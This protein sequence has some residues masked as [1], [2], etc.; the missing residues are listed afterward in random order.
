[1]GDAQGVTRTNISISRELKARM[2]AV[3]ERVNWSAVAA[4]AFE[5]KLLELESR[6]EVRGMDDVI[7]RLKAA[8]ELEEN[9]AVQDGVTAGRGWA[10]RQATPKELRR[11]EDQRDGDGWLRVRDAR[12]PWITLVGIIQGNENLHAMSAQAFWKAVLGETSLKPSDLD[13][14][15]GFIDG[16]LDVWDKV[17]DQL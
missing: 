11:L 5:A 4:E 13:F 14:L 15:R 7:A 6:K 3:G 9:D 8:A 10:M 12:Q 2:D 17:K 16:A 1:M